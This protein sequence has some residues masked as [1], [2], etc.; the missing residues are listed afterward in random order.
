[1]AQLGRD[2]ARG[3]LQSCEGGR[4]GQATS[5]TRGAQPQHR[6]PRGHGSFRGQATRGGWVMQGLA[7][8]QEDSVEQTVETLSRDVARLRRQLAQGQA[9]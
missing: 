3:R 1:M 5:R 6:G 7:A 2:A 8:E 4:A 9:S